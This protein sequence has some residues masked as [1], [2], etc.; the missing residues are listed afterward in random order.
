MQ[1]IEAGSRTPQVGERD[2][3]T[4]TR[5]RDRTIAGVV[6]ITVALIG[7]CAG[8]GQRP[9]A[10]EAADG[11]PLAD[12]VSYQAADRT[13]LNALLWEP[14]TPTKYAV[15]LVP[16]FYGNFVGG[17]DYTPIASQLTAKGYAFM[18][19]NLRT[20]SDF[21]DPTL[22]DAIPDT[23][24]A[25]AELKRR[26]YTD[27]ALFGTSLGGPR[28]MLY[29]TASQEP[30]IKVYGLIAAIMSPYEEAQYRMNAADRKRLEDV[31]VDCRARVASGH[32]DDAI[33]FVRWFNTRSV[34][35]TARGFLN[36]FGSP[37]DTDISTPKR[38][39]LVRVPTVVFHGTKDEISLPPNAEAIYASLTNAK[40][41]ELVW[42]DGA[43]HYLQ[44]GWIAE[45]YAS[46]VSAW[47]AKNMPIATR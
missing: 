25:V 17:H 22:Q 20:F 6:L 8:V 19:I 47:V 2:A 28:S 31:L 12:F 26:G 41:R 43:T 36:V 1:D 46:L 24:A 29:L 40:S 32:G 15:L 34:R 13:P 45:R 9:G 33:T 4:I 23:A 5:L 18:T 35:M 21:T 3:R 37:Q 39:G 42:V 14:R 44:P 7:G 27:I 16:G 30:A 11:A 38:G 10:P